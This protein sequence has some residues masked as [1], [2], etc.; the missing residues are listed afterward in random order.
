MKESPRKSGKGSTFLFL[1]KLWIGIALLYV[2]GVVLYVRWREDLRGTYSMEGANTVRRIGEAAVAAYEREGPPSAPHALCGSASHPIPRDLESVSNK[3]Y[4]STEQDWAED[5]EAN[6][7]FA[8]LKFEMMFSASRYQYDYKSD[9]RQFEVKARGDLNN[10][11]FFSTHSLRGK[12]TDG[13]VQ[14][15]DLEDDEWQE[16]L[17]PPRWWK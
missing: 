1:V 10:D 16:W 3:L 9:G 4:Q 12:V 8:C 13:H 15:S 7:G 2:V 17:L 5:A 11:G 6:V 14:L